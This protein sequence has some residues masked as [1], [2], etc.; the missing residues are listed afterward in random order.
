MQIDESGH[1]ELAREILH[2]RAGRR[3]QVGRGA[4][5]RDAAVS[6]NQGAVRDRRTAIAVD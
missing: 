2:S 6:R 4:D 1:H 5:P 3:F